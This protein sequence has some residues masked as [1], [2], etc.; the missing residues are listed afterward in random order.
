MIKKILVPTDGSDGAIVASKYAISLAAK[1]G[2]RLNGFHVIDIKL[3]EGP[4]LRD[5][6]ASLGTAPFVNY[7]NNIALILDER[8]KAVLNAFAELCDAA[9]VPCETESDTGPVAG[10]IV[11][12]SELMDLIVMGRRG[13]HGAFLGGMLGSTTEAVARRARCPVLVTDQESAEIRRFVAAYDGS[14]HAKRALHIAADLGVNWGV[15]FEILVVGGAN[16][17]D[18]VGEARAYLDAH[19]VQVE[20]VVRDGEPADIIVEYAKERSADLI[21]MGAYGHSKVRELIVG[22]TTA[23]TLNAAPCPVLL[24]R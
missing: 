24:I 22:S 16:A 14:A 6:S 17:A 19:A 9:G 7:R 3:L 8:G 20:Y 2:A 23:A 15:P 10:C 21:V 12:K 4:F 5:I 18:R 11:E 13:E 1:H